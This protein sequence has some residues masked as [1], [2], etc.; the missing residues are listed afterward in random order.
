MTDLNYTVVCFGRTDVSRRYHPICFMLT[1]HE[2]ADDYE[3]FYKSI[4]NLAL[5]YGIVFEPAYMMQD[6]SLSEAAALKIVF[7]K[8]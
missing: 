4:Y 1:S 7:S 5:M 2:E 3:Y 6:A 8:L